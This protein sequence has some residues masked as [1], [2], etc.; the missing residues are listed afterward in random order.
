[1][2]TAIKLARAHF[3]LNFPKAI[4]LMFLM[5]AIM[6]APNYPRIVV[7]LFVVMPI[8]SLF[9]FIREHRTDD[10]FSGLPVRRADIINGQALFAVC[11]E[12]I[13]LAL[14]AVFAVVTSFIP[15]GGGTIAST[16]VGINGTVAF[17]GVVFVAYGVFNAI[18]LPVYF[19]GGKSS[20]SASVLA[21]LCSVLGALVPYLGAEL[22]SYFSPFFYA[23]FHSFDFSVIGWQ[24]L[25]LFMGAAGF[26]ALTYTGAFYAVKVYDK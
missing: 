4:S 17:F 15:F 13:Y 26:F 2:K 18:L 7:A 20:P 8:M 12:M 22:L 3:A 11:I 6:F 10:V 25:V 5:S 19:K 14:M 24:L 1:M 21:A 9:G 23:L 16:T